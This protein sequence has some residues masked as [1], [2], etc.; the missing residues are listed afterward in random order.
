MLVTCASRWYRNATKL[1]AVSTWETR[2]GSAKANVP[3]PAE[4]ARED[5]SQDH[6]ACAGMASPA[7]KNP[8]KSLSS[9]YIQGHLGNVAKPRSASKNPFVASRPPQHKCSVV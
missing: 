3:G 8:R 5:R 7:S 9:A 1:A 6:H 4:Q 2:R